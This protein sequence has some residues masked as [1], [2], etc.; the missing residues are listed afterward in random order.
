MQKIGCGDRQ[1]IFG[2][3]HRSATSGAGDGTRTGDVQLGKL[4]VRPQRMEFSRESTKG[5]LLALLH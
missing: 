4:A 1:P 3:A 2:S 5:E